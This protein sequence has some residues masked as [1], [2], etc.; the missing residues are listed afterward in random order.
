MTFLHQRCKRFHSQLPI[1]IITF[2]FCFVTIA[3]SPALSLAKPYFEDGFLGLTQEELRAQLGMP[4]AVRSRKAALRLHFES[5]VITRIQIG[6]NI[7][8]I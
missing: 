2:L 8:K 7:S 3:G 5:L 1:L 6:K 4:M